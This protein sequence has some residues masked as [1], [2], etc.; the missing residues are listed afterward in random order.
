[1]VKPGGRGSN[2][3]PGTWS[4]NAAMP[5]P[6]AKTTEPRNRRAARLRRLAWIALLGAG[7]YAAMVLS[8]QRAVLF[9]LHALPDVTGD[10]PPA[11]V[12]LLSRE[13]PGGGAVE[14]WLIPGEG[15]GPRPLVIFA[16]GNGEVIDLWPPLLKPYTRRGVS[17]LLVE[18]RGYG[19]SAGTP[20][21]TAIVGDY[22]HFY[23]EVT[24]RDDID[25]ARVVLHGRS[26]GGGVVAQLAQ[27]RPPAAMILEA[28]FTSVADV[29][30]TFLVPRLLVRDPFEV[31][32]VIADAKYPVLLMHG[33]DDT[34]VPVRHAM[35]NHA[36]C[37]TSTLRLFDG[38]GH[39]DPYPAA[40]YWA[41]I[42]TLLARAGTMPALSP[43]STKDTTMNER[44]GVTT[45]KGNPVTVLG[46]ELKVGDTAPAFKLKATDMSDKTLAD[47]AGK[48]KL[49]SVVPSIDTP[50]CDTETRKF[51][52][53]AAKLGDGVVV[54]TVSV[55][56]PP[57]QKR[58]CAAAGIDKVVTLSDYLDH[59]FGAAY[60]V[61]I[62]EIGLLAR[63]IFVIDKNDRI[64]Y[65]QRVPEVAQ[66]PNYDEALDAA[67]NAAKS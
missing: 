22:T 23:D 49:L 56:L 2:V 1:M 8:L 45:L 31:R 32:G 52:E 36:A 34:V 39:N 57:A 40:P 63:T 26:L 62:K 43:I 53:A 54:L 64:T 50:V 19:R 12:E 65:I 33:R 61:R 17:V 66:E 47:Y 15:A 28:S 9:P 20:S 18:Y 29:A 51:N 46:P 3:S 37:A 55:D 42:D 13:L 14:A 21:Q 5:E 4:Y 67:R 27:A 48:V 10:R 44:Q 58:W 38:V 60:G 7:A 11:G 6:S 25:A 24:R 59:A 35:D 30:R 16:H 41:A